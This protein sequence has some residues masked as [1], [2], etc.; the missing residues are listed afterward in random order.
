M[1]CVTPTHVLPMILD[2]ISRRITPE[3]YARVYQRAWSTGLRQ[4]FPTPRSFI[5]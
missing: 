1:N 4:G 5:E 2:A 3:E